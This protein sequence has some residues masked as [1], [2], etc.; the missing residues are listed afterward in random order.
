VQQRGP[1]GFGDGLWRLLLIC[2]YISAGLDLE[3]PGVNSYIPSFLSPTL[4]KSAMAGG[5]VTEQ[6]ITQA[7]GRILVQYDRFGLLSGGSHH[8]ITAEPVTA[9]A[10]VVENVR[11]V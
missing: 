1:D 9:N 3:M 6:Q 10:Q 7:V 4:L 8:Q 11:P 2:G 5:T